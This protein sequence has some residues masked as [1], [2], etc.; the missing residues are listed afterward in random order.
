MRRN[1]RSFNASCPKRSRVPYARGGVRLKFSLQEI[2]REE[3]NEHHHSHADPNPRAL[4]AFPGVA[5]AER[6]DQCR[7]LRIGKV[8]RVV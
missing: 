6:H 3:D 5:S 8:Y 7:R 1:L 2:N 4:E